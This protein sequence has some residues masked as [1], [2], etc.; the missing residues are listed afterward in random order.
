MREFLRRI[1]ALPE[2]AETIEAIGGTEDGRPKIELGED[3]KQKGVYTLKFH[4]KNF[5][6][7]DLKFAAKSVFM[8]ETLSSDKLSV[9]EKPDYFDDIPAKWKVG[10]VDKTEGEEFT[11][12]AGASVAVEV[13][14]TLSDAEKAHLKN[15]FKNGMFIEGF[16]SLVSAT[17]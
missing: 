17:D 4:V 16:L 10:G 7:T 3:E 2:A 9:A 15:T 14:L 13:T 8:T 6:Q 1:A 11:V 5:G 12:A